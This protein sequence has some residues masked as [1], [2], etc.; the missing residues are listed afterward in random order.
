MNQVVG[1]P[2]GMFFYKYYPLWKS[3]FDNLGVLTIVSDQTNKQILNDGVKHC[4]DE[5]CLPVKVFMGHVLDLKDRAD[6]LFIPRYTSISRKEY[7]CPKFGGLPDLVRCTIKGLPPIIDTEINMRKDKDN[8]ALAAIEV[9]EQ[10]GYTLYQSVQ[11]YQLAVNDYRLYR[12][13]VHNYELPHRIINNSKLT[14]L[15]P[16]TLKILLI[17]HV[18]NVYDSCLNMNIISKIEQNGGQVITLEM[19]DTRQLRLLAQQ[20][21]K[22]MFWQ[23]GTYALGCIYSVIQQQQVDGVIYLSSFG[24]GIDSFVEYMAE[25]RIRQHTNIPFLIISLDEHSGEAGMNTRLE[26]FFDTLKWRCRNENNIS[27]YGQCVYDS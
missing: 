11:A 7:I 23:Y 5:S 18:Y 16:K 17:G 21:D 4:V 22:P 13:R 15:N 3:F 19:F 25:R 24:C 9:G 27:S 26:A 6:Y 20:L 14:T 2:R 8:S 10:L 12:S 1:I